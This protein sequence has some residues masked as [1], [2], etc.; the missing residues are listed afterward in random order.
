MRRERKNEYPDRLPLLHSQV[1]EPPLPPPPDS[2]NI[3]GVYPVIKQVSTLFMPLTR[4]NYLPMFSVYYNLYCKV[5]AT[6]ER[7]TALVL[8][9]SNNSAEKEALP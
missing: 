2:G 8:G 1:S 6:R 5:K 7:P 9:I 4:G 3:P